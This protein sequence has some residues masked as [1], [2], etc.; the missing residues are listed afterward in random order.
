[1]PD[2]SLTNGEQAF[3]SFLT[4]CLGVSVAIKSHVSLL[5]KE[6]Q[7]LYVGYNTD[8]PD[9]EIINRTA[10]FRRARDA[11]VS[12]VGELIFTVLI[13]PI[14][15][16]KKTVEIQ[17]LNRSSRYEFESLIVIFMFGRL[18]YVCMY[19]CM[20]VVCVHRCTHATHTR[21]CIHTALNFGP[22][23]SR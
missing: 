18:W 19:V 1:M 6:K 22:G 23:A 4:V 21:A 15:G 16:Y 8:P 13:H 5:E 11:W 7:V 17:A 20:Y 10:R 12:L 2:L 9:I 3:N 14:P